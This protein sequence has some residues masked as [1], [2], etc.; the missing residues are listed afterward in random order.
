[1]SQERVDYQKR[2]ESAMFSKNIRSDLMDENDLADLLSDQRAS[3]LVQAL[4]KGLSE[5]QTI[6]IDFSDLLTDIPE[7]NV[8]DIDEI[9]EQFKEMTSKIAEV[10]REALELASGGKNL[11]S[12][13]TW[14]PL[15]HYDRAAICPKCNQYFPFNNI[16]NNN[17]LVKTIRNEFKR[18]QINSKN[19]CI[20]ASTFLAILE[21]FGVRLSSSELAIIARSFREFGT[22]QADVIKYDEFLRVCLVSK[23]IASSSKK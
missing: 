8:M 19:G 11:V 12:D 7:S 3:P 1:M 6:S 5:G 10:V 9:K 17:K 2:T 22:L 18:A 21:H 16:S 13:A 15:M 4:E 23:P 20:L 14:K